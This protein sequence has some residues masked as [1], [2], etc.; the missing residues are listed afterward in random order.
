MYVC[1]CVVVLVNYNNPEKTQ[2]NW[3]SSTVF[4]CVLRHF[5][6]K[7]E[8]G[9]EQ[10]SVVLAKSLWDKF[11]HSAAIFETPLGHPSAA[12]ISLYGE[13]S[14]SPKLLTK[15]TIKFHIWNQ[16]WNQTTTVS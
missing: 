14:N 9:V 6:L 13:T 1:V 2:Y 4:F 8:V 5:L 12:P 7:Q 11:C 3:Q 15:L 10:D 16:Q